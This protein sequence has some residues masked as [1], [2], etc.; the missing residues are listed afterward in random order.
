[1]KGVPHTEEWKQKIRDI[2]SYKRKLREVSCRICGAKFVPRLHRKTNLFCS[3]PCY[4]KSRLG[5]DNGTLKKWH[6]QGNVPWNKGKSVLLNDAL[7]RWRDSGNRA[8]NYGKKMPHL[9]G[10]NNPMWKGGVTPEYEKLRKSTQYIEWRTHVFQ[11]DDY[12]CQGCGQRG[13]KLQVD[14]EL[15]FSEYPD[16]RLEILNGRTFCIPCH[17][18]YGWSLFK[19][20]N[21][22]KEYA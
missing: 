1:M 17:K 2:A 10:P 12:V 22:R 19:E 7:K 9:A 5:K 18:K 3:K 20:R 21:P 11:R 8:W 16:L 13:G 4:S 14:H 6:A 15:P